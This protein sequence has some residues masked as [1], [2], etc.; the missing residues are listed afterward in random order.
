MNIETIAIIITALS[1]A[2]TTILAVIVFKMRA[3]AGTSGAD[4]SMLERIDRMT[5]EMASERAVVNDN[6]GRVDAQLRTLNQ[7]VDQ[8]EGA[9]KAQMSGLDAAMRNV[10]GLFTN[11]QQRG[12][13]GEL[14]IKRIF[15]SAGMVEG[16]DYEL[17]FTDGDKRPDVLVH[18]PGGRTI[19]ID[20]KFPTARY[21]EALNVTDENERTKLLVGHGKELE[22]TGK[23]LAKKHYQ[24]DATAD[25]VVMYVPSQAVYEAAMLAHPEVIEHLMDVKVIV[26]GPNGVF[27]LVKTAAT[28]MAQAQAIEDAHNILAEVRTV[29]DRLDKFAQHFGNAGVAINKA[30]T[31]FNAAV[32]SWDRMLKPAMGRAT[33]MAHLDDVRAVEPVNEIITNTTPQ[34]LK[35][36]S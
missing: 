25:Y 15:E 6:M 30:A 3:D 11:A 33:S 24:K 29:R 21:V 36:A 10:V 2:L 35:E 14:T 27:A 19:V 32:S 20:S 28:L 8:R 23:G 31:A 17:Q 4:A 1:A 16:R 9:L 7:A 34:E 26:A 22:R 18:I 12:S 13:W 5:H